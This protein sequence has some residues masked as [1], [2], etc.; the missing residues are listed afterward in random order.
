MVK[1]T[2][3]SFFSKEKHMRQRLCF[4]S[5][6]LSLVPAFLLLFSSLFE[7]E[8]QHKSVHIVRRREKGPE[9]LFVVPCYLPI[10]PGPGSSLLIHACP[11]AKIPEVL[12]VLGQFPV[13][14][15]CSQIKTRPL[16]PL[17]F[18]FRRYD[19]IFSWYCS[20]SLW[21]RVVNDE[22]HRSSCLRMAP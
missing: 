1:R 5:V 12:S 11:Y 21:K 16:R 22:H 9:G 14:S 17:Y 7:W 6:N 4:S 20:Q 19:W 18:V 15:S 2:S 3:L 10:I 13:A 8:Q